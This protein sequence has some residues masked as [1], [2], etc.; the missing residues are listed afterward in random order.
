MAFEDLKAAILTLLDEIEKKPE[1]RH[2][3]QE[4]LREKL[5]ELKALGL[6]VPQDLVD[7]ELALEDDDADDFFDNM[8]V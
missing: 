6:P 7:F 8:P 4:E 5:S 2:V 3:L 1:D